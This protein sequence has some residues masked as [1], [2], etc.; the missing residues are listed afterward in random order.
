MY[1]PTV[2]KCSHKTNVPVFHWC[3]VTCITSIN[4]TFRLFWIRPDESPAWHRTLLMKES[5][6][7][8]CEWTNLST[9]DCCLKKDTIH[10]CC[11][12]IWAR[13]VMYVFNILF[14]HLCYLIS[15]PTHFV[16]KVQLCWTH[17]CFLSVSVPVLLPAGFKK[18]EFRW[19][20]WSWDSA[21]EIWM[22]LRGY[23][24]AAGNFAI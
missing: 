22:F 7:K 4:G 13:R 17:C 23:V 9:S 1:M 10:L 18:A 15:W 14:V 8:W 19:N 11:S 6:V 21:Y 24:T 3:N 12:L 5:S 20:A 16:I 2:S